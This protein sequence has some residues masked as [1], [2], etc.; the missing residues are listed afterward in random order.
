MAQIP[1]H[2]EPMDIRVLCGG[3]PRDIRDKS[4]GLHILRERVPEGCTY[5]RV[6]E[7]DFE[8]AE[9]EFLEETWDTFDDDVPVCSGCWPTCMVHTILD[10]RR[11]KHIVR[12]HSSQKN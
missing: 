7:G 11:T 9:E 8:R 10:A 2:L 6:E 4:R 3:V 12:V 5:S 1:H